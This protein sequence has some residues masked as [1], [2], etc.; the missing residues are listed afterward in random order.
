[1]DIFKD[2]PENALH[3]SNLNFLAIINR[4]GK[5]SKESVRS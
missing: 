2:T 3:F 5:E 1:M 4:K